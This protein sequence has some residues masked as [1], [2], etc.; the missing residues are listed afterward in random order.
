M[1]HCGCQAVCKADEVCCS[2]CPVEP[3]KHGA[4]CLEPAESQSHRSRV[5][6][7]CPGMPGSPISFLIGKSL[8]FAFA[9]LCTL[10]SPNCPARDTQVNSTLRADR[11]PCRRV[12]SCLQTQRSLAGCADWRGD[13]YATTVPSC[14][15]VLGSRREIR[16]SPRIH[17]LGMFDL[18]SRD[19]AI[20]ANGHVGNA[21]E[22]LLCTL[23][24]RELVDCVPLWILRAKHSIAV[25]RC[26]C[27]R[28]WRNKQPLFIERSYCRL[29]MSVFRDVE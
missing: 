16:R 21:L 22:S 20:P 23:G 9:Q 12:A 5:V 6:S 11:A 1:W 24:Y 14:G 19:L 26:L 10:H 7:T 27:G 15:C 13:A 28:K 18:P 3:R 8:W 2:P 4:V 17:R 29:G 25:V